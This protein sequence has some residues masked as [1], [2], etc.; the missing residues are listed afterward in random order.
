I[1]NV[2]GA[3]LTITSI[4]GGAPV[5]GKFGGT[6]NCGGATLA[7]GG[8]CSLTFQFTPTSA[9]PLTDASDFSINGI[10]FHVALQG[11]GKPPAFAVSRTGVNFGD[12]QI[13]RDAPDEKIT[14][15]NVSPVTLKLNLAGGA[16]ITGLFGG[17]QNCQGLNLAP[18]ATCQLD[19]AF[20][21]TA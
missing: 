15:R 14:V 18:G 11:N 13:N 2:S 17:S 4:A 3:S 6:Q 20:A 9:G 7:P 5:T 1:E 8:S 10:P 19:F 16:P 21:P 12:T